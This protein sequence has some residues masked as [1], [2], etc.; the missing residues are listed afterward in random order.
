MVHKAHL[1]S[2][3]EIRRH[4][5]GAKRRR[6]WRSPE[7]A[8]NSIGLIMDYLEAQVAELQLTPEVMQQLY[9]ITE[10]EWN[11][12]GCYDGYLLNQNGRKK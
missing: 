12:G 8:R 5:T 6:R 10:R 1:N 4:V 7:E 2:M 11:G 3:I 9:N